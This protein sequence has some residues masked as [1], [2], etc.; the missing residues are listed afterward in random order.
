MHNLSASSV[1]P[2]GPNTQDQ[3]YTNDFYQLK[4]ACEDLAKQ[5]ARNKK[6]FSNSDRRNI[7]NEKFSENIVKYL[8]EK[9]K[10]ELLNMILNDFAFNSHYENSTIAKSSVECAVADFFSKLHLS[11]KDKEINSN[12]YS[13]CG[14]ASNNI[15]ML[16]REQRSSGNS[17]GKALEKTIEA[18]VRNLVEQFDSIILKCITYKAFEIELSDAIT[19]QDIEKVEDLLAERKIN[20]FFCVEVNDEK[21]PVLIYAI[22]KRNVPLIR[23]LLAN[24]IYMLHTDAHKKDPIVCA[25][26]TNERKVMIPFLELGIYRV[27]MLALQLD[28][29]ED[30]IFV[31]KKL[32]EYGVNV[33]SVDRNGCTMLMAEES[34]LARP[35]VLEVLR[36]AAANQEKK[37]ASECRCL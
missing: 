32:L 27:F 17:L 34:G 20:P 6:K 15:L 7:L 9:I 5:I 35:R 3:T 13:Y 30:V 22:E 31:L 12:L 1:E 18:P 33:N 37:R 8:S 16:L 36:Q 10:V 24:G 4:E 25:A 26:K 2:N 19:E 23:M 21:V 29:E 28:N 11:N 14:I